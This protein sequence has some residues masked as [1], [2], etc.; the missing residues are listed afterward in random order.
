[1]ALQSAH[2]G[3]SLRKDAETVDT[4][5][6]SLVA[7]PDLSVVDGRLVTETVR[8]ITPFGEL[9]EGERWA[10]ALRIAAEQVGEHGLIVVPQEAWEGLDADNRTAIDTLAREL[11]VV[12]LTAEAYR[13][14]A[15]PEK[16]T[17]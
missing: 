2:R 6:A 1:M 17:V 9:S 12:V 14:G 8:G 11:R 10:L 15:T 13:P 4:A 5:L 3:E 7:C 16:V